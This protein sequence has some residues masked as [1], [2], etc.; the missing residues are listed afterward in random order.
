MLP[1]DRVHVAQLSEVVD[2]FPGIAMVWQVHGIAG[3]WGGLVT[4]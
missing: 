4:F 2:G 3:D 1:L